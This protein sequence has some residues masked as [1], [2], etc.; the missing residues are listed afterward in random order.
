[1]ESGAALLVC[2]DVI[3]AKGLRVRLAPLPAGVCGSSKAIR[4]IVQPLQAHNPVHR[5]FNCPLR[6]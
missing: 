4:L 5:E 2:I 3:W 1:M 6:T